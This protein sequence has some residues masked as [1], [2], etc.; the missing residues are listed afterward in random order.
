M[1]NQTQELLIQE[2]KQERGEAQ[3]PAG[4][5]RH[6]NEIYVPVPMSETVNVKDYLLQQSRGPASLWFRDTQAGSP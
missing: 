5:R 3:T 1:M 2:M 4:P 6:S